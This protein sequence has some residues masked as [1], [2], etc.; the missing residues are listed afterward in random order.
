[1]TA[2][3]DVLHNVPVQKEDTLNISDNQHTCVVFQ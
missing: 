3:R 2:L 1:M